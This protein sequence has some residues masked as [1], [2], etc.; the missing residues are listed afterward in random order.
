MRLDPRHTD[1]S[2]PLPATARIPAGP[3]DNHTESLIRRLEGIS[4]KL[5]E[6]P[7]A[8][9]A[10]F[11]SV[12]ARLQGY[13]E[14]AVKVSE[15]SSSAAELLSGEKVKDTTRGM[16][17]LL[18]RMGAYIKESEANTVQRVNKLRNII[19]TVEVVQRQLEEYG[20]VSKALRQIGT[21]A[22]VYS[23]PMA[24]EGGGFMVLA[25]NI[26]NLSES[27]KSR[28]LVARDDIKDILSSVNEALGKV[29]KLKDGQYGRVH[30]ILAEIKLNLGS[31]QQRQESASE[32][33]ASISEWSR[34]VSRNIENVVLS[35]QFQDI[36]RQKFE[37]IKRS[38]DEL[39]EKLSSGNGNSGY[40]E[41]SG[42]HSP[43]VRI[44][45]FCERQVTELFRARDTLVNAVTG[46]LSS[47]QDM[48]ASMREM[49]AHTHEMI[50]SGE[51]TGFSF[52]EDMGESLASVKATL[53]EIFEA[54]MDV[55]RASASTGSAVGNIASMVEEI[56]DIEDQIDII[57]LNAGV[58]SAQAG[59]T[60]SAMGVLAQAIRK[61][62]S[63]SIDETASTAQ[64]LRS[65]S[66]DVEGLLAE[67]NK[68]LDGT[69]DEAKRM[70]GEMGFLIETLER[71]NGNASMVLRD[72]D[73]EVRTLSRDID[74]TVQE[75]NAH[76]SADQILSRIISGLSDIARESGVLIPEDAGYIA[77]NGESREVEFKS[78]FGTKGESSVK[79]DPEFPDGV[80]NE[81]YGSNIEFFD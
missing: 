69:L 72:M 40:G 42:S 38:I 22:M 64:A 67:V 43:D 31:L 5:L 26:R 11:L 81:I 77:G 46:I 10:E 4:A 71:L 41:G 7:D 56:D 68:E 15:L 8:T 32:A 55:S 75:T 48:A 21:T 1:V 13:Y 60:G 53:S 52:L 63:N 65:L 49:S 34:D 79:S 61:F 73:E 37:R 45:R 20:G 30:S 29:K 33:F 23:A 54:D 17:A 58:Q 80:E 12:G 76:K 74:R 27:I 6:L 59:Q 19:G 3:G 51:T 47:L 50:D 25:R 24:R 14:T 35:S 44:G 39:G 78:L 57:A 9:E 66:E 28:S 36:T 16:D 70:E 2:C 62:S 18:G